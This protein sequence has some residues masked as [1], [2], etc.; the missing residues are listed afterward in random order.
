MKGGLIMELNH[1]RLDE[2]ALNEENELLMLRNKL[3][4]V[5]ENN[6]T[7]TESID[8]LYLTYITLLGYGKEMELGM[9]YRLL[10][11]QIVGISKMMNNTPFSVGKYLGFTLILSIWILKSQDW[12]NLDDLSSTEICNV[13]INLLVECCN[14]GNIISNEF[15]NVQQVCENLVTSDKSW[16]EEWGEPI[17]SYF[18]T[19]INGEEETAG[20]IEMNDEIDLNIINIHSH[21]DFKMNKRRRLNGT[22]SGEYE[23][24]FKY[25]IFEITKIN[26]ES[27][28]LLFDEEF[29][30]NLFTA[31]QNINFQDITQ[32]NIFFNK[33]FFFNSMICFYRCSGSFL[34]TTLLFK[35][36][37][38]RYLLESGVEIVADHLLKNIIY[39]YQSNTSDETKR[40]EDQA[41][42]ALDDI[43]TILWLKTFEAKISIIL[44][45]KI[46]ELS[47]ES[48]EKQEV[49]KEYQKLELLDD[50][51]E[52]INKVFSKFIDYNL[53]KSDQIEFI[54]KIFNKIKVKQVKSIL[55]VINTTFSIPF[56]SRNHFMAHYHASNIS[57]KQIKNL[58]FNIGYFAQLSIE[59]CF[60]ELDIIIPTLK[61]YNS[62]IFLISRF[63]ES[64]TKQLFIEEL[65]N[66]LNHK[67]T[68]VDLIQK[69]IREL[70]FSDEKIEL[71]NKSNTL[72]YSLFKFAYS[73]ILDIKSIILKFNYNQKSSNSKMTKSSFVF[74]LTNTSSQNTLKFEKV[75]YYK[76]ASFFY[77]LNFIKIILDSHSMDHKSPKKPLF[78]FIENFFLNFLS[79]GEIK[80]IYNFINN[81]INLYN[82][83]R[84]F[85][86]PN[87]KFEIDFIKKSLSKFSNK[88]C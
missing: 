2:A 7:S 28:N 75:I 43:S 32:K 12:Y 77:T 22:I 5:N 17:N 10:S 65:T 47:N 58:F 21:I 73:I 27:L 59:N 46:K 45:G 63:G 61:T 56:L 81:E 80:Q 74:N 53:N 49:D 44:E 25:I 38:G 37:R 70:L 85:F 41:I 87:L 64:S 24:E 69:R 88:S 84:K 52:L 62:T 39:S 16:I 33:I 34:K 1:N 18:G 66:G 72:H 83:E 79:Q 71:C 60:P 54:P 11:D 15:R 42:L 20:L 3:M 31:F 36:P 29:S 55:E 4:E 48:L 86:D 67:L 13:I 26:T 23:D 19:R 14:D 57:N 51:S 9:S 78:I 50:H 35:L 76:I 40:I 8:S 6:V 82:T 30:D 68:S